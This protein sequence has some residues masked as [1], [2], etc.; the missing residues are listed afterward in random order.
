MEKMPQETHHYYFAE[1]KTELN[2]TSKDRHCTREEMDY[3]ARRRRRRGEGFRSESIQMMGGLTGYEDEM[4]N[5]GS[6]GERFIGGRR[7][8]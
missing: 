2:Q 1:N 8:E 6:Q 4:W 3:L 5:P 7:G